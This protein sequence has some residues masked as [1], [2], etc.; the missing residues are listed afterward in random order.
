MTKIPGLPIVTS[1]VES[2]FAPNAL[3]SKIDPFTPSAK[4]HNLE[5]SFDFLNTHG[6]VKKVFSSRFDPDFS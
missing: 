3:P 4:A 2:L 6:C 1:I 5:L